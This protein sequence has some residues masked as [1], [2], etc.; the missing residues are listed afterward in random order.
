M[1][2]MMD[3][4]KRQLGNRLDYQTSFG[5]YGYG[6]CSGVAEPHTRDSG[7][8]LRRPKQSRSDDGGGVVVRDCLWVERG[9]GFPVPRLIFG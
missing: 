3:G 9:G 5:E 4:L 6:S 2:N 7:L 1:A 8:L